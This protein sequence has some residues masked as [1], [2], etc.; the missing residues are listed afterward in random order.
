M[1]SLLQAPAL[2]NLSP[3]VTY[4]VIGVFK[5]CCGLIVFF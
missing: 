3:I 2:K 1:D 4:F 5:Y